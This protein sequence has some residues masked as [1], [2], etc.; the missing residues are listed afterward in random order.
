MPS[1]AL[2]Q[3]I[4][5]RIIK[6]KYSINPTIGYFRRYADITYYIVSVTQYLII[7]I[8]LVTLLEVE[9]LNQYHTTIVLI[10][11][12]LSLFL[13]SGLSA[14]L[15]FR[16]LLW[17][18]HKG[19]YLIIAYTAAA[20]LISINS[21]FI[22][23]FMSLEMQ[24]KPMLI[25]PSFF[26]TNTEIINYDIHQLQSNL[27]FASFVSLWIA[28]TLLL[29]RH[30]RKWGAIKFYMIISF[31]LV[32][33]LGILQLTLSS[34]L[35]QHHILSS[36]ESYTFNVINSILTKPVGGILFGVAFWMVGRGIS[37]KKISNY[38]QLSAIGIILLSIS[39]QDAGLYLLPYPPFG[40]PTISFAGI[41]SYLL[42][43][44][45]YYTLISVSM[46][47][48][49]RKTIEKSVEEQF[50]FVSK[51]GRSQMEKEIE[52]RVKATTKRLA[53]ILEEN[54]GIEA[55]VENKDLEEYV[56]LVVKEKEKMLKG[57]NH[58]NDG[59]GIS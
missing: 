55:P 32:Y 22:A 15:A 23:L 54:S 45:I 48:E 26:Y 14:L 2:S 44:G 17:I 24:G 41:S 29:R 51:I 46:N 4:Y 42:F 59:K 5:L 38:M 28:S 25:D 11:I 13:S 3:V 53:K 16:F 9:I 52:N 27:S 36:F 8:L 50:K 56:R 49:L 37:D 30:R 31:P 57:K 6:R 33:Y 34:V 47:T 35:V 58:P 19:D 10:L 21:I 20:I 40:L 1:R 43:V 12:L 7:A 18:K 39:N